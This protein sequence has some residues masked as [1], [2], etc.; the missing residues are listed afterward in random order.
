MGGKVQTRIA[1][2]LI[3]AIL[4]VYLFCLPRNLFKGTGYS[5]VVTDRNGEL[6]GARTAPAKEVEEHIWPL[7]PLF[8]Y[9]DVINIGLPSVGRE[10]EGERSFYY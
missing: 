7:P 8:T 4:L 2:G 10:P 3:A 6:L 1:C 5:T 9:S